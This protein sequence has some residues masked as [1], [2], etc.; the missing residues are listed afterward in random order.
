MLVRVVRAVDFRSEVVIV[1]AS[2]D[3]EGEADRFRDGEAGATAA[4][5]CSTSAI[6]V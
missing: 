6:V 5:G 2:Q 1:V 3:G 4:R